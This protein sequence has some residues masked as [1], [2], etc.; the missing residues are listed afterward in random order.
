MA[1]AGWC[2]PSALIV[3][4]ELARGVRHLPHVLP[5]PSVGRALA[6]EQFVA[7]A[8]HHTNLAHGCDRGELLPGRNLLLKFQPLRLAI[9]REW[10]LSAVGG[11]RGTHN[12]AEFH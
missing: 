3:T 2:F 12:R 5:A 6:E 9:G 10:A 1:D 8:D 4:G 7:V 11:G